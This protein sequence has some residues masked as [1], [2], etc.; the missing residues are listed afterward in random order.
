MIQ[1]PEILSPQEFLSRASTLPVIDVRS[2]GEFLQGHIPLAH[3]IPLF[4]NTERSEV[5]TTYVQVGKEQAIEIGLRIALTKTEAYIEAIKSVAPEGNAL[6]HCWRGGLRSAK[7]ADFYAEAGY[8][9][10]VL[11]GGYKAYRKFIRSSFCK[12]MQLILIGGYTGSGKTALLSKLAEDGEQVIDLEALANHK[13]S[14]FGHLGQY[15]QP[16]TEQFENNLFAL[17]DRFDSQKPVWVEHES[18]RIGNIYLPDTFYTALRKAKVFF[19]DVPLNQ[20]IDRLV[21]EYAGFATSELGV[22]LTHLGQFMGA[23][24][25]REVLNAL[26]QS[27]FEKVALIMLQYYDRLYSQSLERRNTADVIHI[28]LESKNLDDNARKLISLAY[29]EATG[30]K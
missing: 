28:K 6:L 12:P 21:N 5:G 7:T 24:Q 3:S 30:T 13:G 2:P 19:I 1:S 22:V 9:I 16:T 26:H 23:Y 11:E 15:P 20:R 27:D 18:L 25:A 17:W 8:R 14:N 29:Q 10:S 4:D